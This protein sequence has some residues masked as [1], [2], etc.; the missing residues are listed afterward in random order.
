MFMVATVAVSLGLSVLLFS[1]RLCVLLVPT[2][3]SFEWSRAT[4]YLA[5]CAQPFAPAAEA[6]MRWRL[7]P[8]LVAHVL[9]LPGNWPLAVPWAGLILLAGYIARSIDRLASSRLLALLAVAL[10]FTTGPIL[11]VTM[12]NGINDAWWM[13]GLLVVVFSESY[14]AVAV[15]CAL[16]PWVDERFLLA[17]PLAAC[18]RRIC[19]GN[20]VPPG[21]ASL[22]IVGAAAL[23]YPV[24]RIFSILSGSNDVSVAF[25]ESALVSAP[26]YLPFAHLGWWMGYRGAWVVVLAV[27]W[28]LRLPLAR[29][30]LLLTLGASF[31]GWAAIMILA[32]DLTRSTDVLLPLFAVG[33]C[34]IAKS[35]GTLSA[36]RLLLAL[37]AFNVV[38]PFEMVIYN[39]SLLLHSLPFELVR[40]IK[41]WH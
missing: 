22:L 6:A 13:L 24:A 14:W 17:L 9:R 35:M 16:A 26:H 28:H 27:F 20:A 41:N 30:T 37:L 18:C 39:K 21:R 2:A 5:Q 32:A 12:C 31:A 4:T 15:A 40:L 33:A 3:G 29:P 11:F 7:L 10:L 8:P 19:L 23:V 1:P 34:I 36:S 38:T 25:V